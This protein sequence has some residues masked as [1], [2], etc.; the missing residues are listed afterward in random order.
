MTP[1]ESID[2]M[3]EKLGG[4]RGKMLSDLR[5][6][7]LGVDPEIQEEWK[8]NT[9]VFTRNRN[10]CAL[11]GFKDHLKINFFKA[12][13]STIVTTYSMPDLKQK[14]HVLSTFLRVTNWTKKHS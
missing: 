6:T 4:W 1:T 11:G 7:I 14:R 2:N 3:I 13:R 9:A 12:H 5:K 8:W 10:I